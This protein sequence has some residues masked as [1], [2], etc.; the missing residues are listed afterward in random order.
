MKKI[1]ITIYVLFCTLVMQAQTIKRSVIGA[2]GNTSTAGTVTLRSTIG[3]TMTNKFTGSSA[4]ISQGFQQWSIS[5]ARIEDETITETMFKFNVYPN[6]VTDFVNIESLRELVQA[7]TIL[8]TDING[9]VLQQ[10]ALAD[11]QTQ[12]NFDTY[13]PGTY[14]IT[15]FGGDKKES[16]KVVKQ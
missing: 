12:I 8:L 4:Q 14:I 9:K 15:I 13:S 10:A 7:T 1:S 11:K 3:E 5:V 2:A 16:F 6:P